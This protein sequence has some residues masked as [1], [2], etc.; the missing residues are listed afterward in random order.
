MSLS[1]CPP[2]RQQAT[3]PGSTSA[4]GLDLTYGRFNRVEVK[5]FVAAPLSNTLSARI[6]ARFDRNDDWQRSYTRDATNGEGNI[7]TGRALLRWEP[8]STARVDFMFHGWRD[9][10]E[11]QA[12]QLV[13]ITGAN[14]PAVLRAYPLPPRSNRAADFDPDL[15]LKR[16][17]WFWQGSARAE[18]DLSDAL[19]LTSITSYAKLK[20]N[21]PVDADGTALQAYALINPGHSQDF[22]QETRLSGD[23]GA[24]H[25]VVGASYAWD[26]IYDQ[27]DPLA[28]T[29]SFPFRR[30][31]ARSDQRVK[32]AAAFANVDY[33][34]TDTLTLQG[35]LRY[36]DQHRRFAGCTYDSGAGDFAAAVSR[37]ATARAGRPITV[38][39]GSCLTLNSRFEP[40]EVR[41]NLNEDNISWRAS[42]NWQ[43]DPATLLYANVS[44]GYKNGAFPT[45]GATFALQLQP[46]TQ[47]SLTAYEAGFKLGLLNR[48]VQL[49]GA[50]FYYDYR[51]KQFRGRI[52]D[53]VI[54]PQSALVNV[55]K[56]R[57]VGAELQVTAQPARGLTFSVGATYIGTR[58]LGDFVNYDALANRVQ[59][60]GEA[61]PL[62]P[63]WQV[64]SDAN[65]EFPL[66]QA[67]N[68]FVGGG[69]TY[70][71][72]TNGG[73][74]ELPT[75]D[76][77]AYTL[78]DVRAGV[79]TA[80]DKWRLSAFA[81]NLTNAFYATLVSQPGP[82]AAI[83]VTGQPRTY[84]VTL[85]YRY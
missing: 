51:D 15:S 65:Y 38:A 83:R 55:P 35:G 7:L 20:R 14:S 17:S 54:G 59:M 44:R 12:Q 30:A 85:S 78:V 58:I 21:S 76:I 66:N 23:I 69:V 70:Q 74:G 33:K 31:S 6:S 22:Y 36:T 45:A 57:V 18:I 39:P 40:E 9:K 34:I 52:V 26:S 42:V 79:S 81:K 5:G 48:A 29:S 47:E 68:G 32:T 50:V 19:T 49:N 82:D 75:F 8:T 24:A 10:S 16:D 27:S 67:L 73:L 63:D 72:G 25:F 41:N 80:D 28:R 4:A 1:W 2:N 3:K 71:A 84:G 60:A 77:G 13:A 46:A 37:I 11:S 64:T 62:T 53:P 56:S 43:V 61:F